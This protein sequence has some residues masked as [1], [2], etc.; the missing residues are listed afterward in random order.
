MRPGLDPGP[1]VSRA[2]I[3]ATTQDRFPF[4]GAPPSTNEKAPDA[5]PAPL[6]CVR[7]VG[8][9]GARGFLWAPLLAELSASEAFNEP[10]P[11]EAAVAK[12][13]D[14]GRFLQRSRRR[15]GE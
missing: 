2:S 15:A 5:D 11:V 14:P 13:L 9:L 4:C 10:L 8:G 6:Q 7:L 3:R 12:A 1:L